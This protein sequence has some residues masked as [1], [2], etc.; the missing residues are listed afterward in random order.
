VG[1]GTA[2]PAV[3]LDVVG[4]INASIDLQA[5]AIKLTSHT[6][7]TLSGNVNDWDIGN[8]SFIRAAGGTSDKIVTGFVAQ[9]DGHVMFV[10]NIGTTNK[11]TFAH[12]SASSS[13]A[14]RIYTSIVGNIEI[15]PYHTAQFIYDAT[16]SRWR[17][18]SHL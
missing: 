9:S 12:D 11:I 2:T 17:E 3:K 14:N 16:S 4:A 13:A 1:I 6:P 7:A 18:M 10:T 8:Y 5:P 15:A